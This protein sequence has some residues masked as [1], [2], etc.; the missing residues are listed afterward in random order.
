MPVS[1]PLS[2]GRLHWPTHANLFSGK[3]IWKYLII[4]TFTEQMDFLPIFLD[5]KNRDCVVVGGGEVAARKVAMLLRAGARVTVVSP[6]LGAEL[7]EQFQHGKV[8]YRAEAFH[9]RESG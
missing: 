8:S 9:A 6:Q 1:P 5:I 3:V 7:Y 4:I 2:A